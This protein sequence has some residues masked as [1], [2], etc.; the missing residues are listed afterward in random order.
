MSAQAGDDAL[1][2]QLQDSVANNNQTPLRESKSLHPP[3]MQHIH[4]KLQP[5]SPVAVPEVIPRTTIPS[6]ARRNV[7]DPNSDQYQARTSKNGGASAASPKSAL[8]HQGAVGARLAAG[9]TA[10]ATTAMKVGS[11]MLGLL[12]ATLLVLSTCGWVRGMCSLLLWPPLVPSA[13]V[14]PLRR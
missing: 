12:W 9:H 13:S 8:Q 10:E 11:G 3:E 7:A 6:L 14:D 4:R 1:A 2:K 5:P